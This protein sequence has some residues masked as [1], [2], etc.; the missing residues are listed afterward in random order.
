MLFH[1]F[2]QTQKKWAR[3]PGDWPS[4]HYGGVWEDK[5]HLIERRGSRFARRYYIDSWPAG[6]RE[7]G[8]AHQVTSMKH[9]G[10]Y[11]DNFQEELIRGF[12]LQLPARDG[13]EIYIPGTYCTGWEGV[14]LYPND[15]DHDKT[16]AARSADSY[17]EIE[18][19]AARE[20]NAQFQAE[21]EIEQCRETIGKLRKSMLDLIL[22]IKHAKR[23]FS[24]MVCAALTDHL[25][26]QWNQRQKAFKRIDA[27]EDNYWL[28]VQ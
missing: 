26:R 18:A 17:A 25:R 3:K 9:T 28:A 4:I 16:D 13:K 24:P 27:L 11:A 21:Q 12:V 2:D 22:E 5:K 6:W 14:T 8:D 19:E 7:I 1:K 23:N 20:D 10:W 15:W